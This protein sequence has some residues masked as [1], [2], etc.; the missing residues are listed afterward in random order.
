L[1]VKSL[2]SASGVL[3]RLE[4]DLKK[5]PVLVWRWKINRVVGMAIE[6][7]K[8]RNDSAVRVRV[9]FGKAAPKP[10]KGP[11][12]ILKLF[13]SFGIQSGGKEP[14]GFKI[15]YIWGS[16]VLKGEVID[17]PGSKNH[18]MVIVESG[19]KRARRWVWEKR[20]LIE[21][22]QKFFRGSPPHLI[23]IVVLTDTDQTNEGVIAHYSSIIMMDKQ[24]LCPFFL[25]IE[26]D[27]VTLSFS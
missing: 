20:N 2:G 8:D 6:A 10:L 17:Y 18:K 1:R 5:F 7:Q 22:F 26:G 15:D 3:R 19:N 13:K 21:D 14:R 12:E 11:P 4:I 23:G 16:N 24:F 9:I 25:P 27:R